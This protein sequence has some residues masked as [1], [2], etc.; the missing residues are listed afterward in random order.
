M[1]ATWQSDPETTQR[2][3]RMTLEWLHAK[4]Q[5]NAM[6]ARANKLRDELDDFVAFAGYVDDKGHTY[7]DLPATLEVAGKKVAA[8][9]REKRVTR[10]ANTDRIGALADRVDAAH[11]KANLHDRLFPL[12]PVL[13]EDE[14]Y[15]A[16]QDGLLTEADI[17]A[18]FDAKVTWAFTVTS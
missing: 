10:S 9:K 12:L 15:V 16:Y 14:L 4:A 2:I 18:V 8:L 1:Q 11:P 7:L 6:T 3:T 13:D 17:D 5:I